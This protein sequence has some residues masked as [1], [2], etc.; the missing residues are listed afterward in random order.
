MSPAITLREN[1]AVVMYGAENPTGSWSAC[2]EKGRAPYYVLA[3]A[4]IESGLVSAI[5]PRSL[6]VDVMGRAIL[7]ADIPTLETILA[8]LRLLHTPPATPEKTE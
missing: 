5:G 1:L 8:G 2:S 4:V 7:T 3:S 6:A